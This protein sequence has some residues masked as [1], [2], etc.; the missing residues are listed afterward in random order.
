MYGPCTG[1]GVT[2][3]GRAGEVWATWVLMLTLLPAPPVTR[4]KALLPLDL[5][6]PSCEAQKLG[7]TLVSPAEGGEGL[8]LSPF[9]VPKARASDVGAAIC[10]STN[11]SSLRTS[12]SPTRKIGRRCRW[13]GGPGIGKV[14]LILTSVW[15]LAAVPKGVVT[16]PTSC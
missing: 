13:G 10:P 11:C 7:R 5:C 1:L 9:L 15:D 6:F 8:L 3:S 2:W 4:G 12:F 14:L 16:K